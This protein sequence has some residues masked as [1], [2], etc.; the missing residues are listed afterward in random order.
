MNTHSIREN[1]SHEI[2]KAARCSDENFLQIIK[3]VAVPLCP[4]LVPGLP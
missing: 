1:K 3:T 2:M 4:A